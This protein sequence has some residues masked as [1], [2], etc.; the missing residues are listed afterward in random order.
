[1]TLDDKEMLDNDYAKII[2]QNLVE[3]G[4]AGIFKWDIDNQ[5]F[6]VME[7]ITGKEF[8]NLHTLEDFIRQ[9]VFHK[10]LEVAL[11][12]LDDFKM[13]RQANY[14]STFRI[15]DAKGKIRWLFCKGMKM[16]NNTMSAMMYDVTEGNLVQGHDLTTNLLNEETFMRKLNNSIQ[17]AQREGHNNALI[18]IDIDNFHTLLNKHG[19]EF[20]NLILYHF[21][22][23]LLDFV[24]DMD[25]LA[26]FPYNKFMLLLNNPE[27]LAKI[28]K[29]S[30]RISNY[31]EESFYI[32][33][34]YVYLKLNM[35]ITLF[36]EVSADAN[37]LLQISE[38]AINRSH[39]SGSYASAVF[40]SE[41]MSSYARDLEIEN[42]L[43]N[44]IMNREF[45]LV[46]QPQ[47]DLKTN[48]ITGFE[49]LAR[50]NNKHLGLISPLDF[51]PVAEDK[52]Y[53]IAIGHWIRKESL[54]T[55]RKWLDMGIEFE[56]ISI[57][58][59]TIELRQKDFKERLLRM[60]QRY[61]VEPSMV[62]LEITE[63]TLTDASEDNINI[64]N[65]LL[66]QGF[67]IAL[68]DFGTGYSNLS[69]LLNFNINTLKID[70]SMID[71]IKDKRQINM[72]KSII[73]T[74][75]YLAYTIIAE[76]VE[77]AETISV[78]TELGCDSV[79]G[80]FYSRPL[81]RNEM[82]SFVLSYKEA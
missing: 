2:L 43:P 28:E 77:D 75:N 22:C 6:E 76:G 60:C 74:K 82:E 54:K 44:G 48:K 21:S 9:V 56:N 58:I 4:R 13:G 51:I 65:N 64:I 35:G 34:Q 36:P 20:G 11:Q 46:Y 45:F 7:T 53:V 72:L 18:Y 81:P 25:E 32:N 24:G 71:N 61:N 33:G 39:E 17:H 38:F 26:S 55:A 14:Q 16:P 15:L 80:Y 29:T 8:E 27:N 50:W 79:Q 70:K 40:D 62:E 67:K 31:F 73:D 66:K 12:D 37:E 57:N 19:F 23:I 78:L 3:A 5:I 47:I 63:R 42:E 1:M 49:A 41:L 59:S 10:D 30:Q 52:G 69:T 68:D